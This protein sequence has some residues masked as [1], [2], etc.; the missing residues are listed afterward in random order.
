MYKYEW[1]LETGGYLL[2]TTTQGV[3]GKELRPVYGIELD[4]LGFDKYW[5]YPK[6]VSAPL[7]WAENNLYYYQGKVVGKVW[8]GSFSTA[9]TIECFTSGLTLNPVDIRTMVAKNHVILDAIVHDTLID[10]YSVYQKYHD[11]YDIFYVAFSGG[12]DSVVALDLVHRALPKDEYIVL[13]GDT[14]MELPD[15]YKF[16]KVIHEYYPDI[17]FKECRAPFSSVDSW[18]NFGPPARVI[19]WCCSVHK[20]APQIN[21]LRKYLG[22]PNFKGMAFTGIRAEESHT[23]STYEMVS[24]SKKHSGQDSFHPILGWN[25]AELYLYIFA[26]TLPLND[27]YK[28][29][30]QRVGCLVCP[31]SGGRHE[32]IKMHYYHDAMMKY[33]NIIK[34]TSSKTFDN[35]TEMIH[36]IDE[37][38]WNARRSGREITLGQT[39]MTDEL[40]KSTLSIHVTTQNDEW[41]DWMKTLGVFSQIDETTFLLTYNNA[42]YEF[43][44]VRKEVNSLYV[45]LPLSNTGKSEIY[46]VSLFKNVFRKAAYCK[47]CGACAAECKFGFIDMSPNASEIVN[48]NCKHCLQCH[49]IKYG[50]LRYSSIKLPLSGREKKMVG[51]DRYLT[52]GFRKDWLVAYFK[53]PEKYWE[54]TDLGSKM[55]PVC[56]RFL[57]DAGIMSENKDLELTDQGRCFQNLGASNI[58]TWALMLVNLAYTPQM[59][60]YVRN[61]HTNVSYTADDMTLLL[62]EDITSSVKRNIVEACRNIMKSTPIGT[63]IGLGK[64]FISGKTMKFLERKEWEDPS[65]KVILYS[66][67]KY[68]EANVNAEEYGSGDVEYKFTL[69]QLLLEDQDRPGISPSQLFSLNKNIM[70][71][72]IEG[73]SI[74]YPQ[75]ITTSFTHDLENIALDPDK[76]SNDL[77]M[78]LYGGTY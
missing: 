64:P 71:K 51:L 77:L 16:M 45:N 36:F 42:T 63:E 13:F 8:G 73:L 65:P 17:E 39:L 28:K 29:G 69:T 23:R 33:L 7:L 43:T 46:F 21:F 24:F 6:D 4:V 78:H 27:A 18:N 75:F 68:V 19:R 67:Y 31:M 76:T 66:L 52:F 61:I 48:K 72:I 38:G 56:K 47:K 50:C 74:E 60:W 70:Q 35:E 20:T 57:R 12:K 62:S 55:V 34:N 59:N 25:T 49:N 53:N 2:T 37:G 41:K 1:D 44:V 14:D 9:P 11:K 15:T 10:I 5:T 30:C 3:V 22:K 32:Y 58:E 40:T 26:N 54:S